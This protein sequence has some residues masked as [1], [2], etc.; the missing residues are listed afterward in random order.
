M[1][2]VEENRHEHGLNA[3]LKALSLSKSTWHD[4]QHRR[5]Q[6]ERDAPLKAQVIEVIEEH[7]GYG[8]RRILEEL[9]DRY[10][11]PVNH[12]RLRRVLATYELG[13]R[14]SLPA[15]GPSPV[16]KV[17]EEAGAAKDLVKGRRFTPLEGFSTD[18]TELSYA[19]GMRKAY[20][21]VLLCIESRWAGG[22]AAGPARNRPLAMQALDKL[23]ARLGRFGRNLAGVIVHHDRDS[24]YTSHAW[25]HRVL[26]EEGAHVSYAEH[27]A[28]DNPWIESFWGRFKTENVEVLLEAETPEEVT[29]IID[30]QVLYYN[31]SRRHSALGYRR[32]NEVLPSIIKPEQ[33]HSR[34]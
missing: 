4:R 31:G 23:K 21:M 29:Q 32:P 10:E 8:Y 16:L 12:K 26:I 9:L 11:E 34:R 5:S 17:L 2:L 13:L 20:L 22:W 3:C 28:K 15:A 6:A 24:V 1:L 27:G 7:P 30:E 19:G 14:R 33:G 25:L 18:F